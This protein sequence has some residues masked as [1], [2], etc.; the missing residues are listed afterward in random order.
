MNLH[1]CTYKSTHIYV[2]DTLLELDR[3]LAMIRRESTTLE[4]NISIMKVCVCVCIT[5]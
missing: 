4:R 5:C 1:T 3:Q 2:Q